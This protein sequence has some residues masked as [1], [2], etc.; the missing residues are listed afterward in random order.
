[1]VADAEPP[2]RQEEE[3]QQPFDHEHL[4]PAILPEQPAGDRRGAGDGQRLAEQPAVV[5]AGAFGARKPVGQQH[6]RRRE[7]RA[8]RH[9]EKKPHHLELPEALG[10][11]AADRAHAPGDETQADEFARAPARRP[12][13]A[14]DLQQEVAE[15]EDARRLAL[16]FVVHQQILHH[17]GDGLGSRA[18]ETLVRSIYEIVYMSS[19]T[20]MMC[21]QRCCFIDGGR[22]FAHV[23]KK[24][25]LISGSDFVKTRLTG[26]S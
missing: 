19:A 22:S 8:L 4:P 6:Q 3:W 12:E 23:R 21:S 17:R 11:T 26:N 9:A 5:G 7:N 24:S 16:H 10:E 2:D 13:S 18:S 14:G 25:N 1:M 15:K 20:G